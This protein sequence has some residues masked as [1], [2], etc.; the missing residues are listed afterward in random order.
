MTSNAEASKRCVAIEVCHGPDCFGSGGG[1]VLLELEELVQEVTTTT[2]AGSSSNNIEIQKGG[3]RNYCSMGPNVHCFVSGKH[4]TKVKGPAECQDVIQ[5][6]LGKTSDDDDSEAV[7]AV[8]VVP[9]DIT[10]R[11]LLKRADRERWQCLR[12][13]ARGKQQQQ[14]SSLL[15]QQQLADVAKTEMVAT[16]KSLP[17]QK[18]AQRRQHRLGEMLE[19]ILHDKQQQQQQ[20][21]D[22]D[23]SSSDD[24]SNSDE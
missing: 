3:C 10:T 15:L 8:V 24:E 14:H 9:N 1:A 22:D 11:V 21:D 18:R 2:M 17:L 6:V 16:A 23:E 19:R 12:A 4:F 7:V 13:M 20:Q 5:K